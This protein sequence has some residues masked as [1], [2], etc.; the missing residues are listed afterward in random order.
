[1]GTF[2]NININYQQE[3]VTLRAAMSKCDTSKKF[4]KFLMLLQCYYL[5]VK[6]KNGPKL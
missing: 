3:Y 6:K 1:M 5:I 2:D 4:E